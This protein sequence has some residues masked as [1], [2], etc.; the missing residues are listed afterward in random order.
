MVHKTYLYVTKCYEENW[1][2]PIVDDLLIFQK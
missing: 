2:A 1:K